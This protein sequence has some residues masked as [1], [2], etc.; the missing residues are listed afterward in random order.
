MNISRDVVKDLIPV[1]LSGDAERRHSGARGVLFEDRS[2]ACRR[3]HGGTWHEPGTTRD[4]PSDCGEADARRNP[5]TAQ[6]PNVHAGGRDDLHRAAAYVRL[7]RDD[8]HVPLDPGCAS[9]RNRVVGD[10]GDHVDLAR[11]DPTPATSLRVVKAR[12]GVRLFNHVSALPGRREHL[13][14]GIRRECRRTHIDRSDAQ[15]RSTADHAP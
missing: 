11:E 2:R 12:L 8:D 6:E 10:G 4:A 3:C 14:R 13:P 1:Y 5:A 9:H 15:E 7:S